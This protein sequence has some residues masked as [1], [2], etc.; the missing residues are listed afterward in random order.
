M[1]PLLLFLAAFS[2]AETPG[3]GHYLLLSE[4]EET[5]GMVNADTV[6]RDGDRAKVLALGVFSEPMRDE[7]GDVWVVQVMEEVDCSTRQMR[8][9]E[10]ASF[11]RSMEALGHDRN[12]SPWRTYE[13]DTPA[14]TIIGFLCDARTLD[15]PGREFRPIAEDYWA[16][17]RLGPRSVA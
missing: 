17:R 7:D 10:F 12:P 9:F 5:M 3:E 8:H 14:G 1:L 16:R 6:V 15:S 2:A 13:D 4:T 11:T